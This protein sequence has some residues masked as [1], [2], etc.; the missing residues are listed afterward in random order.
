MDKVKWLVFGYNLP[1]EPTRA[2]G[3]D[4]AEAQ[5]AR[6]CEREAVHMV[7]ALFG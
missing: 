4:M 6:G 7:H 1:A 5:E 2:R 3:V